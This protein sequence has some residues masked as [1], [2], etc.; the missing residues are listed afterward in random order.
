MGAT[1]EGKK[2][3]IAVSDG[4]RESKL[5]WKEMLLDL[6]QRRLPFAGELASG[7]GALGFWGALEEVYPGIR[8][9]RCCV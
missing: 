6:K 2:E 9:Q 1:R 4:I 3:L 8:R 7:D 5:S